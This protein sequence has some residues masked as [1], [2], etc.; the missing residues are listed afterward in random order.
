MTLPI[1]ATT[2][3]HPL[4]SFFQRRAVD[5][6]CSFAFA[7]N[8]TATLIVAGMPGPGFGPQPAVMGVISHLS[9]PK[10]ATRR[11]ALFPSGVRVW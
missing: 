10:L 5:N 9:L 2:G 4:R 6:T 11:N 1:K 3:I 8:S 7:D